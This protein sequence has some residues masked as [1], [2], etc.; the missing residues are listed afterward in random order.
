[1][2]FVCELLDSMGRELQN[3]AEEVIKTQFRE[4]FEVE[5]QNF[6]IDHI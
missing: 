1:M 3:R 2:I 6:V 5:V 4:L